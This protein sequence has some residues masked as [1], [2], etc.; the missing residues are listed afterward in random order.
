MLNKWGG[1]KRRWSGMLKGEN[2]GVENE[3]GV[4]TI[5]HGSILMT[6]QQKS[7]KWLLF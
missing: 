6:Y 2:K 7:V 5:V 3:E 1:R 4:E